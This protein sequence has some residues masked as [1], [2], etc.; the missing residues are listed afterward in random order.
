MQ[1]LRHIGAPR[2]TVTDLD[3]AADWLRRFLLDQTP[4]VLTGAGISI[5]SGLPAYRDESGQWQHAQPMQHRDFLDS[6][7]ARQRYWQRAVV[8][9][10]AFSRAEPS[11][12]HSALATWQRAGSI[13]LIATQNVDALH[14]RAGS[15]RVLDLHGRLDQ[16][17]CMQCADRSTR[18]DMQARLIRANPGTAEQSDRVN[19]PDGDTG[20]DTADP[21]FVVPACKLCE[22]TL[23]PDVVFY[24]DTVPIDRVTQLKDALDAARS[25]IVVGSS[26]AVYSGFRVA[27]W[28][29]ETGYPIVLINPGAT[30]ADPIA[31]IRLA[32]NAQALLSGL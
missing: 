29:S 2:E 3:A 13:G 18:A 19:R 12:A 17:V 27:R 7:A 26:L 15:A 10:S 4:L 25:L 14:Q 31:D 24:G 1:D 16:V 5:A 32:V 21:N 30:R 8:G 28:A 9:W 11:P 22:G 20:L 23:K 6:P